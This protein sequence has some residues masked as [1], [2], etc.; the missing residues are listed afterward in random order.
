MPDIL[1]FLDPEQLRRMAVDFT[2]KVIAALLVL[3]IFWLLV[4]VTRPT[5]RAVLRRA[6][7]AEALVKLL[8]DNVYKFTVLTIGLVM[9]A[10]QL[11]IDVGAAL[12]GIGVAGLAVGFAAQ[13]SL[14]NT[15]AG[16]LIFWD[17]PFQV[18]QFISTEDRYGKVT[19]ITM[20]TTRIRTP[21]NV[22]VV[23]PNRELIE[24][25]LVNHS[26]YGETRVNVPIGIAYKENIARAREALLA[27]AKGTEGVSED[28]APDVVVQECGG[29]SVNLMVR[30]WVAD[31][32]DERPVFFRTLENCKVALD[33]AGIEI[34]FP[35]LQL[36]VEDIRRRVWDDVARLPALLAVKA[37]GE[38][39]GNEGKTAGSG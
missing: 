14:A 36:F 16:F 19:N 20:R 37:S 22:Y 23:I 6:R 5:L 29:S 38:H 35:H 28:H 12:A 10:S 1:G 39:N 30:V 13:D 27:A 21:D 9:A 2:P 31:A 3:L 33:E 25:V 18:G 26:M 17:K 8:V 11:G 15:I 24:N 4:K 34:P 32:A 7:F